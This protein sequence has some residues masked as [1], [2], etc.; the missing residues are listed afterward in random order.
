MYRTPA[1]DPGAA[2]GWAAVVLA[3]CLGVLGVAGWLEPDPRGYGTH[4]RLVGHECPLPQTLGLPCPSCGMTTAFALTV[5]GRWLSALG[6]QPA[7]F[8]LCL[9]V[10]AAA[11]VA[12]GT[13][14]S[15]KVWHANWYRLTPGRLALVVLGLL[16]AGWGYKISRMLTGG[17]E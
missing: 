15:G 9:A 13:V 17:W 16:L 3:A 10:M 12:A 11:G 7:G 1:V 4:A 14:V 8:A 5:R 2:R 6:A